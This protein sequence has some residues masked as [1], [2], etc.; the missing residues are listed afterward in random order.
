[1]GIAI[2]FSAAV[3]K[4]NNQDPILVSCPEQ[5][6]KMS[7]PNVPKG[8]LKSLEVCQE[9][10]LMYQ[11]QINKGQNQLDTC[12]DQAFAIREDLERCKRDSEEH[13]FY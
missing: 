1:M 10:V 8:V 2:G 4:K 13:C 11:S 5:I 12:V 6:I 3:V 9:M 7:C